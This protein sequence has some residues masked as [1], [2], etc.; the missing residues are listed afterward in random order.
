MYVVLLSSL[1]IQQLY[2]KKYDTDILI[3]RIEFRELL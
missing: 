1:F 2:E 3:W